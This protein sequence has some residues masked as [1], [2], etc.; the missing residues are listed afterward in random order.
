MIF[1][2]ADTHVPERMKRLPRKLLDRIKSDDVI[3]HAGDFVEW[4]VYQ[5]LADLATLHAVCG[6]MDEAKLGEL[7][8]R[9]KVVELGAK[10]IGMCHGSGSGV[11][12][13]ERV[14]REFGEKC[15]VLIFGHSHVPYNRKI[16]DTLIFNPGSLSWNMAP[17][18]DPTYGI[19][20]VEGDDVW[21]EVLELK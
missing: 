1:V 6:N 18:F 19:L 10:K 8:P 15:D 17:P 12:L 7:L 5:Q 14:H 13:G 9:K 3:F 4:D 11:G 20:T 16:G 2:L 21:A